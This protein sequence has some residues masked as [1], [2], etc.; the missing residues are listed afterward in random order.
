MLLMMFQLLPQAARDELLR[1]A[2]AGDYHIAGCG[3][4]MQTVSG[5]AGRASFWDCCRYPRCRHTLG[6]RLS[7]A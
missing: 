2:T 7:V 6:M 5:K 3:S 1:F 4:R